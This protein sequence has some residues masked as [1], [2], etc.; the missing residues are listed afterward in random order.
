MIA[1]LALAASLSVTVPIDTGWQVATIDRYYEDPILPPTSSWRHRPSPPGT[2]AAT[3][4]LWM[5][6]DAWLRVENH[7]SKAHSFVGAWN[8]RNKPSYDRFGA[9]DFW[10]STSGVVFDVDELEPGEFRYIRLS[11]SAGP[12]SRVIPSAELSEWQSRIKYQAFDS[13][14][15]VLVSMDGVSV[16]PQDYTILKQNGIEAYIVEGYAPTGHVTAPV[17]RLH[18]SI[19]FE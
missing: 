10:F 12:A 14:R 13:Y 9:W 5:E 2:T 18:G 15:P 8:L 7:D 19:T 11:Y 16:D 6:G 3:L 1:A 17:G 4:T